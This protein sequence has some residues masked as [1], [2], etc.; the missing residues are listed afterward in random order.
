MIESNPPEARY[1]E[2]RLEKKGSGREILNPT[3]PVD[4]GL[5]Q[6]ILRHVRLD[7]LELR[8]KGNPSPATYAL[9]DA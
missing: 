5:E 7:S 8:A 6:Y 1:L 4:R 9:D 3:S 2:K